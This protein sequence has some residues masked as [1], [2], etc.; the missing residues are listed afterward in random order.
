LIFEII[1]GISILGLLIVASAFLALIAINLVDLIRG[2]GWRSKLASVVVPDE[3]LPHVLVQ[4]PV[5]NESNVVLGAL[6]SATGLDW[7]RAKLHIQLLDDSDDDTPK[8]AAEFIEKLRA[9]GFDVQHLFRS[10]RTGFKAG[11][12]AAG[13]AVS[14]AP[15]IAMLDVDFRPPADWLRRIVPTMLADPK[16]GFVQSRCEFSNYKTN[17]LTRVQGMLLDSHFA[18]E[19]AARY[20]AGWLFQ[21]N[22]TGGMWRRAAIDAAGGWSAD[23]LCEDLD[24]TIRAGL[25]G[26]HGVFLMEP[27]IP[28]LV[29]ERVRHWRVQQRRWSN[30]FVQVA[31]KLM[32]PIWLSREWSFGRK[33]SATFLILVQAFYPCA[34]IATV[35]LL[36]CI[37]LRGF[38]PYVYLPVIGFLLVLI[39]CVAVGLT[40]MP[41]VILGRGSYK[42]YA[43][44]A[45]LLTPLMIYLSVSNTPKILQTAFGRREQ[46]KRTPK[47]TPTGT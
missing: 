7:P 20:R 46:F 37:L 13:L 18:M 35:S 34:A 25:A 29:P 41:F 44:T 12:L 9:Q 30:G 24:L 23:S 47:S 10:D 1:L 43:K 36:M 42:D 17:W 2:K 27:P 11:A 21:F 19:Q 28:G 4:I 31:H 8:M 40:L 16:A 26:W 22:G 6:R 32:K 38:N 45:V 14:D 15:Y 5:F 39:F 33:L 3:D